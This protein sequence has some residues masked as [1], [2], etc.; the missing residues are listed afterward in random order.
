MH[1]HVQCVVHSVCHCQWVG[2]TAWVE[3]TLIVFLVSTS[4]SS[5]K[6]RR[7]LKENRRTRR[8]TAALSR[9]SSSECVCVT[10]Y[11]MHDTMYSLRPGSRDSAGHAGV[12]APLL[13]ITWVAIAVY[14]VL[15]R[16]TV[17]VAVIQ[18]PA[19]GSAHTAKGA[20]AHRVFGD[21]RVN[22]TAMRLKLWAALDKQQQQPSPRGYASQACARTFGCHSSHECNDSNSN[23]AHAYLD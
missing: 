12:A 1:C 9:V 5:N 11:G 23:A 15:L 21:E 17:S 2:V 7:I 13:A 14:L 8:K 3:Y 22:F 4:C 6:T 19:R 16:P 18:A 10:P 20:S